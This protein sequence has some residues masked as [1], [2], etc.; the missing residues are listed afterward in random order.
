MTDSAER[1]WTDE[2]KL[3]MKRILMINGSFRE[4]GES[5]IVAMDA[6]AEYVESETLRRA[7]ETV[8]ELKK[9][10]ILDPIDLAFNQI[11]E[12]IASLLES[13]EDKA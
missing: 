2:R 8:R 12:T 11:Y 13:D 10:V 3:Q 7:A 9:T 1:W 5:V 4:R 6:L